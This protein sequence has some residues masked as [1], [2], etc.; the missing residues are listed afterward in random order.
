MTM[1]MTT[2]TTTTPMTTFDRN[3]RWVINR[4]ILAVDNDFFFYFN[5]PLFELEDPV[6]KR[7]NCAI[8]NLSY[9]FRILL[10]QSAYP[11][12]IELSYRSGRSSRMSEVLC[13]YSILSLTGV[14]RVIHQSRFA[15]FSLVFW[16][17][18]A[19]FSVISSDDITKASGCMAKIKWKK[20]LYD[21][22]LLAKSGKLALDIRNICPPPLL[23]TFPFIADDETWLQS[24]LVDTDG[25]I[26]GQSKENVPMDIGTFFGGPI[27]LFLGLFVFLRRNIFFLLGL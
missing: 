21:G 24:L 9:F 17:K 3:D 15:M 8:E 14:T 25:I 16:E 1:V 27:F 26:T 23:S 6:F 11:I 20:K 7:K 4:S 22:R 19:S 2:T 10:F 12:R 13:F 5:K 18:D